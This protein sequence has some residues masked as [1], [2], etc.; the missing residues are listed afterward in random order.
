[1]AVTWGAVS[2]IVRPIIVKE[3]LIDYH[4]KSRRSRD[5]TSVGKEA[6]WI[7]V[8]MILGKQF[9]SVF[10]SLNQT[11]QIL[12]ALNIVIIDACFRIFISKIESGG[13]ILGNKIAYIIFVYF[14]QI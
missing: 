13:N 11:R 6:T 1:M 2:H 8:K 10:F 9:S 14:P 12:S 3:A 4:L 5:T 7:S